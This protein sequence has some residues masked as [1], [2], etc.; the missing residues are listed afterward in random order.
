MQALQVQDD[1][2][3]PVHEVKMQKRRIPKKDVIDVPE[4]SVSRLYERRASDDEQ[5]V[6]TLANSLWNIDETI[7]Q[8][9]RRL[10]MA[11]EAKSKRRRSNEPYDPDAYTSLIEE[12]NTFER[13]LRDPHSTLFRHLQHFLP[14]PYI[15][16]NSSDVL[17]S[18]IQDLLS[19]PAKG[20]LRTL[21]RILSSTKQPPTVKTFNILISRLTR[22]RLNVAAWTSFQTMI[23]LGIA[24][25]QYT[26]SSL[27]N[28]TIVTGS[29]TDFR[30]VIV[31]T[32]VHKR[33]TSL[34]E[35]R[36]SILLSTIIKGCVKFQ[37]MRSA[38]TYVKLLRAERGKLNQFMLTCLVRGYADAKNWRMGK[39]YYDK[40]LALSTWDRKTMA[41][42]L[43]FCRV[44][45]KR[46]EIAHVTSLASEKGIVL[47]PGEDAARVPDHWKTKGLDLPDHFKV[48]NPKDVG[49]LRRK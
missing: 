44:C 41:T 10:L 8:T 46:Q 14:D 34:R 31:A 45:G 5:L 18:E 4:N 11:Y 13:N 23:K 22:L 48:Y 2:E 38:E 17:D 26:M 30:K 39:R 9:K 27:L 16:F 12:I 3:T 49:A 19:V 7:Q 33:R 15:R 47:Q 29:Y 32:R 24:P 36:H 40:L 20:Q 21:A 1:V 43:R 37:R 35:N 42:L 28:L 25:D 6:G